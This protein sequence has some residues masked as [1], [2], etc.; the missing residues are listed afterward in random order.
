V[1]LYEMHITRKLGCGT[2]SLW[3]L[4]SHK[5]ISFIRKETPRGIPFNFSW[6][7]FQSFSSVDIVYRVE[8][9]LSGKAVGGQ[10]V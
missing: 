9:Q 6:A 8:A 5:L 10:P 7:D 4:L 2:S 3:C 1:P